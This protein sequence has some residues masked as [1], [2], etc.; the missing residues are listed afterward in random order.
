M[1]WFK[2][3]ISPESK[4]QQEHFSPSDLNNIS[5][6]IDITNPTETNGK[7]W[8][9]VKDGTLQ[10]RCLFFELKVFSDGSRD[11]NS[12]TIDL[13]DK[14]NSLCKDFLESI[15][16]PLKEALRK[17]YKDKAIKIKESG[18]RKYGGNLWSVY[19]NSS[20]EQSVY[21]SIKK[22]EE[23]GPI[24]KSQ[25]ESGGVFD[26]VLVLSH[27]L[28]RGEDHQAKKKKTSS[29]TSSAF[30]QTSETWDP[31]FYL[32]AMRYH[33]GEGDTQGPRSRKVK[34]GTTAGTVIAA[35]KER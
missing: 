1:A 30:G 6:L 28:L 29:R 11:G 22:E 16:D 8:L 10:G 20:T 18:T 31:V 33:T 3:I 9:T 32:A 27:V 13:D 24:T 26:V 5:Q 25:L 2:N 15:S 34:F 14:K 17:I 7:H 19:P 21:N 12:L 23:D 4:F 35:E